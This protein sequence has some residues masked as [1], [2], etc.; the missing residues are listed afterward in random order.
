[1]VTLR[2]RYLKILE[3]NVDKKVSLNYN[4]E[5]DP[6]VVVVGQAAFKVVCELILIQIF[7]QLF[8]RYEWMLF[9]K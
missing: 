5:V 4:S 7:G 8:D 3:K 2:N 6:L 1:M 9:F